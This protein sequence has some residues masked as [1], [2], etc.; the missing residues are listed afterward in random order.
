LEFSVGEKCEALINSNWEDV[1]IDDLS[2]KTGFFVVIN[3]STA[4]MH[5]VFKPGVRKK[6]PAVKFNIGDI[7]EW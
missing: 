5:I 3:I 1:I 7:C 4:Q 6:K 2:V